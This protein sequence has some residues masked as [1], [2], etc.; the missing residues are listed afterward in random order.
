MTSEGRH[1][2]DTALSDEAIDWVVRL[3]S[4]RATKA[5]HAAFEAWRRGSE[6]HELAA[7]EAETIWHGVGIVGAGA[8]QADRKSKLT[9]RTILGSVALVAGGLALARSG[10]IGPHLLADHVTG[11]GERRT[12]L[13][14][15]GS[16]LDLNAG[17]AVSVDFSAQERRLRIHSGQ[18][19]FTVVR[20]PSRP[21]IVAARSGWT[22]AVGTVFDIDVRPG[23]VVVT[24]LEGVVEIATEA[25]PA[26]PVVAEVEQRVRYGPTARP[27][28]PETIDS[29]VGTAWRRG[30]LIFDR[31]PLGDVV[32]ELE[33]YRSGR[34]VILSDQ[35]PALEVTGVFNLADPE[36]VLRA[37]EATLPVQIS[38]L[39]MVT[40]IR[41]R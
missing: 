20:D 2:N 34:I 23:E 4:G 25:A 40:V 31:R 24:V 9:R 12:V 27:S 33:R 37:I 3:N 13:L 17:T 11:V 26:S 35:L 18:A 5:D 6:K 7:R 22:R 41:S 10:A 1:P 29:N 38:Q 21:F 39:P 16:S 14:D 30:K 32:A 36:A 28:A 19:A 8:R 15:D